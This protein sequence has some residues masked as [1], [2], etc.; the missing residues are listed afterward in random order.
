[1]VVVVGKPKWPTPMLTA[2]I[3]YAALNPYWYVPSD[4]A[5]EDV[6]QYVLKFGPQVSRRI[7]L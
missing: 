7:W 2:Y 1:M 4:L 5:G 3:R 6:G